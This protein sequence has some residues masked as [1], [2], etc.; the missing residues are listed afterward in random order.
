MATHAQKKDVTPEQSDFLEITT[1]LP[2]RP[3]T[4]LLLFLPGDEIAKYS[5]VI[6]EMWEHKNYGRGKRAYLAEFDETERRTISTLH[7]RAYN[8]YMRH[9]YPEYVEM[10]ASNFAILVRAANFFAGLW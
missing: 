1:D 3:R 7:T 4:K 8:W 9:G 6:V 5:G 10:S 2:D